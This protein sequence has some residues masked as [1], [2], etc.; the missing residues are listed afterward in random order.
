MKNG[1]KSAAANVICIKWGDAYSA[2]DVNRLY[3]MVRRNLHEHDLNFYCFTD[4]SDGFNEDI[5]V[6]PLPEIHLEDPND[7]KYVYRKEVGLCADDLADLNGQRVLF[8][9]LDVIITD[10]IDSM[11]RFAKDDEFVIINDW[12]SDGDE[13]GQATCYSW[14]V[15]TLGHI[16]QDFESRPKEVVQEY[17]TASQAY[18]SAMVRKTIGPLKFWPE[19]WCKSFKFH[20]LPPW[21]K[22]MFEAAKLP[23]GTKVLAFHGHP[24][25]EDAILGRW[26][27]KSQPFYTYFYKTIQPAPW[28]KEYW[29]D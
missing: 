24:K 17:F 25:I 21:Y 26:S 13:V 9:D 12:N 20:A 2:S 3:K 15:G 11:V 16:K 19:Q 10:E 23:E 27:P 5:R 28:V 8:F 6:Y 22:R 18:L 4:K 1:Q 7:L 14:R 29:R